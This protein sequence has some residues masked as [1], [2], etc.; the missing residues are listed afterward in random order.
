MASRLCPG[1]DLHLLPQMET[2]VT[3]RSPHRTIVIECKYTEALY[4]NRFLA[5][6]LRPAHLYQLAAY[7]RNLEGRSGPDGSAEGLLLY[8]TVGE[9]LHQAYVLHSHHVRVATLDLNR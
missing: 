6:K 5:E 1:S 7:L 8:P 9:S 2:D 3:I 4:D